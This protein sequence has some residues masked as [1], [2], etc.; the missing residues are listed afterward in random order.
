MFKGEIRLREGGGSNLNV[1]GRIQTGE[2]ANFVQKVT[3]KEREL[4]LLHLLQALKSNR[5][6]LVASSLVDMENQN[7]LLVGA[8]R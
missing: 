7:H 5:G 8:L 1:R 6:K 2:T 4:H 3:V